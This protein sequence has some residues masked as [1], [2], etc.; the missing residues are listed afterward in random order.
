MNHVVKADRVL[1]EVVNTTHN[2]EDTE[3]EDPHTDD[4]NDGSL[5]AV[6][7]PTED[8]E[9]GGNDIDDEDGTAQLPGWNGGPEWT[10]GTG[11]E[12]EPVLSEGDLQEEDLV[13][14][15]EVLDDTAVLSV[16]QHGGE[17]DPGTDG[18]NDTEEDGHT[19]ELGQ[20]PLD[21]GLGVWSVVVGD[22]EGGNIGEN[23]NEDDQFQVKRSVE[24]GDPE[25]QEDFQMEGKGDTVDDVSVH[26]MEDLTG[27]LEGIDDSRE[28]WGKE[29]NIGSGTSSV[30]RTLDSNTG[31]SL[32][33]RWG[34]V[35]TVTSH[36]NEV[37]TLL[38]NL[39]DVVLVLWE[40]LSETIGS[41]N[42]IVDLRTWHL[43]SSSETELLSIVDVGT[44]TELAGS[45]TS[46]TDGITSQH[47]DRET[48]GLGFVDSLCGIVTW[49]IR[50]RHDTENLPVTFTASAG[51]TE[52]TETTGSEFGNLVL[53]IGSNLLWDW[54]VFLDSAENEEWGTLNTDNAL[55]L[56]GLD[57]G[58]NLLGD[59]VEW[60]ELENL[61]LGENRL[62]TWVVAERLEEGLVDGIETLLLAGSSQAGS[63][64]EILSIDTLDGVWLGERELVLGESTGLVRAKNLNTS[65][66]LNGGELLDDSLLLGEVGGTDSHGGGD[67]SWET[68]WDTN[69]G[70][71]EGEAEDIDDSVGAVER[72][73]PDDQESENDK[74]QK[75]STNTVENLSEM[76]RS[77]GSL[78]DESGSATNESV[79]TSGGNDHEGLTTLDGRRSIARIALVLV[80]GQRFTS[81]GRLID[82]EESILSNDT[83]IGWDNGTL[84]VRLEDCF[85]GKVSSFS[86]GGRIL[87]PRVGEY[88]LERLEEHQSRK[89]CH[90]GGQQP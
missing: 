22:G 75:D 67:D 3:R 29:D 26:T 68:D 53:V 34:I 47:L 65:E 10:V 16:G 76:T 48:E 74:A 44:E 66:G 87:P 23:G 7:E 37:T 14:V 32:L 39:D 51:N 56:W 85:G 2:A 77:G 71:S 61:V 88:H 79:V 13:N 58:S 81:D 90:H 35:D 45:F 89:V 73:N 52:G 6:L 84:N 40:D 31:I 21:W 11:D 62:G 69:D 38:K 50:A 15:T 54:V 80:D 30:G 55:A 70:N 46:D 57:D 59:G 24:N 4:G 83:T 27:S 5:L 12:D 19:P 42:E 20:V 63:K 41:L 36:G 49:G 28:T 33:E 86:D 1:E 72:G 78:V 17:S 43:T 25:T 60:V 8:T 9:E 64:H 82:L 18:E